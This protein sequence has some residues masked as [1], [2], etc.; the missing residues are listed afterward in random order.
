MNQKMSIRPREFLSESTEECSEASNWEVFGSL[1]WNGLNDFSFAISLLGSLGNSGKSFPI[2]NEL[3]FKHK[4][5]NAVVIAVVVV[6]VVDAAA[7]VTCDRVIYINY[8]CKDSQ[9]WVI[10]NDK[11][12]W[13][14][15]I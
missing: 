13:T 8:F 3:F 12:N 6:A 2:Q 9:E 14:D 5:H 1:T 7:V 15:I 10:I 4:K 11:L